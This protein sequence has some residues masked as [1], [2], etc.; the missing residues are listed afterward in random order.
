MK[1]I[2][3]LITLSALLLSLFSCG[4]NIPS[5]ERFKQ[6]ADAK[7]FYGKLKSQLGLYRDDIFVQNMEV[8]VKTEESYIS[9]TAY[10]GGKTAET[11]KEKSGV[12]TLR[13][14]E[15]NGILRIW[16]DV[17]GSEMTDT[18]SSTSNQKADEYYVQDK[19]DMLRFNNNTM[20][21]TRLKE[22]KSGVQKTVNS[23]ITS[24]IKLLLDGGL[25]Y[26]FLINEN[27]DVFNYL[28]DMHD[29]L[30]FDNE[31]DVEYYIDGNVFTV[32]R[33]EY[34]DEAADE[35]LDYTKTETKEIVIQICIDDK[36]TT[37]IRE[38]TTTY[39][40]VYEDYIITSTESVNYSLELLLTY[41][42]LKAPDMGKYIELNKN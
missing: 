20:T 21:Y 7:E 1:K 38:E 12:H 3:S 4:V 11:R 14:D 41:V 27:D 18:Q 16:Y 30:D 17:S 19:D 32:V 8:Y 15:Q 5:V 36:K 37:F 28:P 42:K 31:A 26:G 40:Y 10:N 29:V 25:L 13:Y 24:Q 6:E 34:E 22:Q 35:L 2:I 23:T 33:T 9:K 39:E